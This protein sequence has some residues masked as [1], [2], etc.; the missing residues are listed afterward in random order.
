MKSVSLSKISIHT[1]FLLFS[2]V[3]LVPLIV[4][5]SVSLS[6]EDTIFQ[7]GYPIFP[8]K[9][10]LDAY[11]YIF[12]GSSPILKSYIVTTIVA[13]IGTLLHLAISSM[14]A[15]G[16]SR[17]EIKY[18]N[19]IAFLVMFCLLFSG[20]LVPWYILISK[21]LHLKNTIWVLIVP[22]LVSSTNVL[23]MRNFFLGI[24]DAIIESARIDGSGE[25]NTFIKL[26]IPLSTPVFATIGLFVAVFYWNDWFTC[27]LFVD[28][29]KLYT[30]QFLLQSI[31]TNIAY[32]QGTVF[33]EKMTVALPSETARMAT[34][35]L[36][37]GPI[38]IVYPLLQKFFVKGLT[39]GAV[40][41]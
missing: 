2:I 7:S 3:C 5:L 30:L 22:Y 33:A 9:F 28:D 20:G 38:V 41:S 36:A 8:Q 23:V 11:R 16:L 6:N 12:S 19:I 17:K 14:L 27:A 39:L 29:G 25:F 34:C 24:P 10:S 35:V 13:V 37:I 4:V 26:V 40:K 18:R 1:L 15:Y 31:M 21:Y 32:L